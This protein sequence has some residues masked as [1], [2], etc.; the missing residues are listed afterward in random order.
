MLDPVGE[1]EQD[2]KRIEIGQHPD[3]QIAD[4]RERPVAKQACPVVV[5]PHLQ[6][7][8]VLA[9]DRRRRF[10]LDLVLGRIIPVAEAGEIAAQ[11]V[12]QPSSL[13]NAPT[14]FG[15]TWLKKR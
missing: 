3:R 8:L 11:A 10:G 1:I 5:G 9:D 7:P 15:A 12:H 2:R 14:G 4:Q 6:A 13:S